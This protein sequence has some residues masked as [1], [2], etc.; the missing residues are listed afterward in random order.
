MYTMRL[1][2]A[3]AAVVALL[4]PS[5][6]AELDA[7]GSSSTNL[8]LV[9]P[10][11]LKQ[12]LYQV[13]NDASIFHRDA[14]FG[15][16]S[17]QNIIGDIEYVT[18]TA[19]SDG[20]DENYQVNAA[21][22]NDRSVSRIFMVD[23]GTCTFTTKARIAQSKGANGLI[24]VNNN[25]LNSR[26]ANWGSQ[27]A[28]NCDGP[29]DD[30]LPYMAYDNSGDDVTI[31]AFLIPKYDGQL[32]KD[33]LEQAAN[34]GSGGK[35]GSI[36]SSNNKVLV[37]M[38]LSVPALNEVSWEM[39]Q[40]ADNLVAQLS[41]VAIVDKAFKKFRSDKYEFRPRYLLFPDESFGCDGGLCPDL[42]R[43]SS[44]GKGY[45][46]LP[47]NMRSRAQNGADLVR[48]NIRQ[49]CI[50]DVHADSSIWWSFMSS[51]E[52]LGCS[53]EASGSADSL[54]A[55]SKRAAKSVSGFDESK[56]QSCQTTDSHWESLVQEDTKRIRDESIFTTQLA[57][58][59]VRE[60]FSHTPRFITWLLCES[61][62]PS[63]RPKICACAIDVVDS[64]TFRHCITAKCAT[65]SGDNTYFCVETNECVKDAIEC[66]SRTHDTVEEVKK[67]AEE[68]SG[69]SGAK[70][71]FIVI[72]VTGSVG[73]A[74][75]VYQK[76]QRR[77]MQEEVRD[78]LSEYM[79]LEEL[80]SFSGGHNS[81]GFS[82]APTDDTVGV[83]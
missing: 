79:P 48:E 5:A 55:C 45:C 72:F 61:F 16:P 74:A 54:E 20:C 82:R 71:F 37:N 15:T 3:M 64:D 57:V 60:D 6:R 41:T 19:D 33:C 29:A 34:G 11:A 4:V 35:L 62:D 53:L 14:L 63:N 31:P 50:W 9:G 2:L 66:R 1:T 7:D 70:I 21:N 18:N 42:C 73:A 49:K 58:N 8:N 43:T 39:W 38:E 30:A 26:R 83:I 40:T 67:T 65:E 22:S 46:S 51:F 10:N 68:K 44:S 47:V 12:K 28:A 32:I 56:V 59:G 27:W 81:N 25:C 78:I 24:V 17:K 80:N 76:R 77:Q 36:C 52:A 13:N 75:F 69:M 23:R